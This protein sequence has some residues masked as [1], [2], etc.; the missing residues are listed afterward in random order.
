MGCTGVVLTS[1]DTTLNA[2]QQVVSDLDHELLLKGVPTL[3][4]VIL[5]GSNKNTIQNAHLYDDLIKQGDL[6]ETEQQTIFDEY[7][8]LADP[9]SLL[10]I[11]LTSGSIDEPKAVLLTNFDVLNNIVSIWN[12]FGS[13]CERCCAPQS[14][15]HVSSGIWCALLP[16]FK[17]STVIVPALITD[18]ESAI[19]SIH[20]EKCTF[21][22]G[23]PTFLRKILAHPDRHKYNLTS[24]RYI[25]TGSTPIQAQ[26]LHDVEAKLGIDRV[27]QIYGMTETGPL[28]DTFHCDDKRRYTSVGQCMP[29]VEIKIVDRED[30]IVPI[31]SV[32]EISARSRFMMRG[33]HEDLQK[34]TETISDDG[35]FRTGDM[36]TMDEDG[37]LYFTGR[38]KEIIIRAGMN[39]WPIE[40]EQAIQKHTSVAEAYVFPIPDPMED[41]KVCAFVKPNVGMQCE[42]EELKAFLGTILSAY[43]MPAHIHIV[44]DFIRNSIG[45]V[46]K[47]KLADQMIEIL[48]K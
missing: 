18:A 17:K 5:I 37:Y 22:I 19:R 7:Q 39:I 8:S 12:H 42:V 13:L 11:F 6:E 48:D 35:W 25:A 9:N 3:K 24:L 15:S 36:G 29:F 44:D 38:K 26:F 1:P 20:E 16:S 4:H 14:M 45:K 30:R 41:E 10:S 33:Y 34:T 28:T 2:S 43:K 23:S 40:I 47:S 27:G 32:G 31:G 46:S 21:L